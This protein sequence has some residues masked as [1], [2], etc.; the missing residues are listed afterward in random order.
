[1]K[2][3]MKQP[4]PKPAKSAESSMFDYHNIYTGDPKNHP[5]IVKAKADK[6]KADSALAVYKKKS[7]AAKVKA[8]AVAKSKKK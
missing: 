8:I 6:V 1:M 5:G 2:K 3:V 4:K 7:D